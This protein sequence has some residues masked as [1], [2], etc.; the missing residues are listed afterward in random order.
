MKTNLISRIG[1]AGMS[2]L[3]AVSPLVMSCDVKELDVQDLDDRVTALEGRLDELETELKDQISSIQGILDGKTTVVSCEL[4]EETGV[5]KIVLSDATVI[6]VAKAGEDSENAT[7]IGVFEEDGKYYWTLNGEPM[8]SSDGKNVPVSVTPGIRVNPDTNMWEVSPDGTT[9]LATGVEAVN[10]ASIFSKVEEDDSFVYFT[11]GDGS[12]IK[13]A[14]LQDF[15]CSILVGKQFVQNG[16][17]IKIDLLL[18]NVVKTAVMKPDGWKASVDGDVLSITAPDAANTYA[19]KEGKV[20]VLAVS[21]NK[22]FTISEVSVEVGDMPHVITFD[23]DAMTVSI[24]SLY[25]FFSNEDWNGFYYGVSI[26]GSFSPEAVVENLLSDTRSSTS[27][28]PISKSF[29]SIY[30]DEYNLK[31]SYVIWCIDSW[32]DASF[33]PLP[34]N[35]D[36]MIYSII[37]G[38]DINIAASDVTFEDALLDV[39]VSGVSSYYAA[40]IAKED[41]N[42]TN[43]L[44][45]LNGDES[46]SEPYEIVSGNFSGKL[47]EFGAI[48]NELTGET[49]PNEISAGTS[50]VVL[51]VPVKGEGY[52]YTEENLYAYEVEI[53]AITLGGALTV[54]ASDV[55]C[56]FSSVSAVLTPSDGY[57]KYYVAYIEEGKIGAYDTDEKMLDYLLG[58]TAHTEASYNFSKSSLDSGAKGYIVAVALDK[59]GAAGTI[60]RHEVSTSA[61]TFIDTEVS[62]TAAVSFNSADVTVSGT[63]IVSFRYAYT[64]EPGLKSYPFG[65]FSGG[66]DDAQLEQIM[67]IGEYSEIKTIEAGAD[68]TAV[69]NLSGLSTNTKYYFFVVGVDADN[70]P[71]HMA[72][73]EFTPALDKFADVGSA[74]YNAYYE[75]NRPKLTNLVLYDP[76]KTQTPGESDH[77]GRMSVLPSAYGLNFMF[78]AE[79]R[80]KCSK[81]WIGLN[82][83]SYIAISDSFNDETALSVLNDARVVEYTAGGTGILHEDVYNKGFNLYIVWQDDEGYVYPAEIIDLNTLLLTDI[84]VNNATNENR[85]V[86]SNIKIGGTLVSEMTALPA[87]SKLD[88]TFDV[89][90]GSACANYRLLLCNEGDIEDNA[91]YPNITSAAVIS[92]AGA[93][94]CEDGTQT[95]KTLSEQYMSGNSNIYVVWQDT[96]GNYYP[97]EK[98]DL[99]KL[100][101]TSAQ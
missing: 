95:G 15:E 64:T 32:M 26:L 45:N 66:R 23:S 28:D 8:Q 16:E 57:Y 61:I 100:L 76:E 74:Q 13:V 36:D 37:L 7:V 2:I 54:T 43:V 44:N 50:Y 67:A 55:K 35:P 84:F 49:I 33:E 34:L 81:Y 47:S 71:T 42:A 73:C 56:D 24:T 46:S 83:P 10:G 60:L 5:Y 11:L 17:T 29:S 96:D 79:V 93:V 68:G 90:A 78:D 77:I 22:E 52:V 92:N 63:G 97:V 98:I 58:Q 38:E 21:S 20:S 91:E 87:E 48:E 41:Y 94:L 82:N 14:K 40:V 53:P 89:A 6:E 75:S 88:L 69:I 72:N 80:D 86:L 9:W 3:V 4:N 27:F 62:A 31:E 18:K 101:N 39:E 19:E 12:R 25:D 65:T 70:K 85:P 51:V 30:G 99:T 1:H 59:T